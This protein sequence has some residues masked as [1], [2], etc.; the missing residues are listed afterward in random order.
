MPK[1]IL[2][3]NRQNKDFKSMI[4]SIGILRR[5]ISKIEQDRTRHLGPSYSEKIYGFYLVYRF[6]FFS[7]NDLIH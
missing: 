3:H 6:T 2:T 4:H 5:I 7:P 1:F